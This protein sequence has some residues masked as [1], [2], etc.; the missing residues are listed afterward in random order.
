MK[1]L[2]WISVAIVTVL[3]LWLGVRWGRVTPAAH[4]DEPLLLGDR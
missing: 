2:Y 3:L 1:K 4:V